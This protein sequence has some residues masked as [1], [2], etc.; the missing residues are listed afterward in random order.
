MKRSGPIARKSPMPPRKSPMTPPL[1]LSPGVTPPTC[2]RCG[3]GTAPC[4][5]TGIAP[6]VRLVVETPPAWVCRECHDI[7]PAEAAPASPAPAPAQPPAQRSL[8]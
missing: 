8:L 2:P 4:R 7:C 1:P 5:R 6:R 3:D